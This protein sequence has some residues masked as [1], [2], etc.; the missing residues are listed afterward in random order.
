[1]GEAWDLD[2][3]APE[4][5]VLL[6]MADHADHE[7]EGVRPSVALIAHK[8]GFGRS[9]VLKHQATLRERGILQVVEV[10]QAEGKPNLYRIVLDDAPRKAPRPRSG[11]PPRP[12]SGPPPSEIRTTPRPESGPQ[13]SS[14]ESSRKQP[15]RA[16]AREAA[17]PD[18]GEGGVR[19]VWEDFR[20]HTGRLRSRLDSRRITKIKARLKDGYTVDQLRLAVRGA[21]ADPFMRGENDRKTDYCWPE[22]IFR[23]AGCVDRHMATARQR[24]APEP[25]WPAMEPGQMAPAPPTA[26]GDPLDVLR[27][28]PR[29]TDEEWEAGQD[30]MDRLFHRGKYAVRFPS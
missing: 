5:L 26:S 9:T 4:L 25:W 24:C 14:V 21:Y 30:R 20:E 2:L 12:E 23:D 28:T 8:T 19:E 13:E 18:D 27:T 15:S 7:G 16:Q 6:A 11:P 1:M 17:D 3:P 22:T 29:F 10:R